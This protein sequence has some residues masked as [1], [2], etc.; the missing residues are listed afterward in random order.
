M[1]Q[2]SNSLAFPLW[3]GHLLTVSVSD[4]LPVVWCGVKG[5]QDVHGW[6][7]DE[8]FLLHLEH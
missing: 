6:H 1:A 4:K 5:W 8:A 2:Q 7:D 3:T